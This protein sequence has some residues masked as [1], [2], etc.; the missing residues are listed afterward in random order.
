MSEFIISKEAFLKTSLPEGTVDV[1]GIGTVRIR[2]LS[3]SE[4]MIAGE[5]DK[6]GWEVA[7]LA[8]GIVE[9]ELTEDEVRAWRET[10]TTRVVN[11]VTEAVLGLSGMLRTSLGEAKATFPEGQQP[12]V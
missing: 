10:T 1:P 12:Q 6:T 11:T 7:L 4:V 8:L 3:R 5:R 2:G 9:P